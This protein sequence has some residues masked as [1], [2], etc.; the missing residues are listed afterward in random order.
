MLNNF[1]QISLA[2]VIMAFLWM[3]SIPKKPDITSC[4]LAKYNPNIRH[5]EMGPSGILAFM[6]F[7]RGSTRFSAPS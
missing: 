6:V 7:A 3:F 2:Q 4:L 1:H 5:M